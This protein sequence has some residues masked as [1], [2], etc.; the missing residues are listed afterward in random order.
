M[1]FFGKQYTIGDVMNIDSG[2]QERAG[3]C[4]VSLV[5]TFHEL[6]DETVLEKFKALV[7]GRGSVKKYYLI[8]K[9]EVISDK[10]NKHYVYIRVAPDFDLTKWKQNNVKIY[11]DCQ[12]FKY[13]SAYLLGQHGSLFLNS[14]ISSALGPAASDAPRGKSPTSLLCKHSYAALNYLVSNYSSLMKVV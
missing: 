8:F 12:D 3:N 6:K 4:K 2:R 14:K 9:F 11:C 10:G 5:G 7:L 13:R 1:A